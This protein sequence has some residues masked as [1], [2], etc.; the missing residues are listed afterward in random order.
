[1]IVRS[2]GLGMLL[3]LLASPLVGQ[4]VHKNYDISTNQQPAFPGGE[5]AMMEFF[6]EHIQYP[7]E[8]KKNGKDGE[9]YVSFDVMPDGST[10]EILVMKDPGFGLGAEAKRVVQMMKFEPGQ[11]G[12]RPVRMNMTLPVV[13]SLG[14]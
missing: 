4:G 2:I 10:S 14:E 3:L 11:Q 5:K 13:F 6:K 8:A 1:M 7:E 9:V 12:G